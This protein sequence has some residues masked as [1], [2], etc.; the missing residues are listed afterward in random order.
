MKINRSKESIYQLLA[1]VPDPEIPVVNIIEMGMIRDVIVTPE[2]VEVFLCPTYSGCPAM[3]MIESMVKEKLLASGFLNVLVTLV[4]KP[5]WTTDWMNAQTKEKLRA[6][7][8]APPVGKVLSKKSL[9][10]NET[11][12]CPQ[13]RSENTKIKSMFGS[14]ACKALYTC[15]DCLEPFDYFKCI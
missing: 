13:C 11:V 2:K 4:Y 10:A 14:T 3:D 5:A 7:G 15:S 12:A 6:F 9:L 1:Q 8:I